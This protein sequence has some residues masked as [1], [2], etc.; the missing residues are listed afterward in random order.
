MPE[1]IFPSLTK[2]DAYRRMVNIATTLK[3]DV[4]TNIQATVAKDYDID[5]LTRKPWEER[6]AKAMKLATQIIEAKN[7]P[8]PNAANVKYPLLTVGCIQFSAR[9]YPQIIQGKD[10]VKTKVTGIDPAG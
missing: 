6:N 3:D 1:Y 2:L 4:I 5:K 9:A 10:V 7:T 8:W